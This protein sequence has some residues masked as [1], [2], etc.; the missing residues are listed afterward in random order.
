MQAS[1]LGKAIRKRRIGVFKRGRISVHLGALQ[2][3]DKYSNI[4]VYKQFRRYEYRSNPTFAQ[5]CL[6]AYHYGQIMVID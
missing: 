5:T 1:L 3:L 6:A 4:P 2:Q